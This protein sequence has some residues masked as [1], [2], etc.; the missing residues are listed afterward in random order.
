MF[1]HKNLCLNTL[2]S[3]F[4]STVFL[5][6][7]SP[8]SFAATAPKVC[9]A[10]TDETAYSKKR[11]AMMFLVEGS[12]GYLFI[13][14][15]DL[16]SEFKI[17][18][19]SI[20]YA[21]RFIETLKKRGLNVVFVIQP[22]RGLVHQDKISAADKKLYNFDETAAKTNF[23]G[24]IKKLTDDGFTVAT[25]PNLSMPD[26]AYRRDHHWTAAGAKAIAYEAARIIKQEPYY[27]D[28][29]K[30][31]F[32]T[33]K[34]V[35]NKKFV[36]VLANAYEDVCKQ[37]SAPETIFE[38]KTTAVTDGNNSSALFGDASAPPVVLAGTS[39]SSNEAAHAN[40]DGW[41]KESLSADVLNYAVRGGGFN[42]GVL[43]YLASDD[44]KNKKQSLLVWEMGGYLK[45]GSPSGWQELVAAPY[46]DCKGT[47]REI[48]AKSISLSSATTNLLN[49]DDWNSI[50]SKPSYLY[51]SFD[52]DLDASG[53]IQ[54]LQGDKKQWESSL[55][56]SRRVDEN[57]PY[58]LDIS[59]DKAFDNMTLTVKDKDIGRKLNL[60]IC[61][62]E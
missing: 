42:S 29:P 1:H 9:K 59:P 24:M 10:L 32:I 15:K 53:K 22:T 41:L 54:A 60:S 36:G 52:K 46:G 28:I 12:D 43:S 48:K 37:K 51:F 34:G 49:G 55:S 45:F 11:E 39:F 21:K 38:Y 16:E 27:N 47:S 5:C 20:P 6:L 62:Y 44:Y 4:I 14:K 19:K 23:S 61:R 30:T 40:F 50:G 35:E 31:K 18:E 33:D 56:H 17:D 8:N 57:I 3:L 25:L 13:S 26:Y 58:Y 2:S 7:A